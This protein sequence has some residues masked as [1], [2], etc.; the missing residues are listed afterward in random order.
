MKAKSWT[1]L[2]REKQLE[3]RIFNVERHRCRSQTREVQADFVV[4]DSRD[5]V[6]IIAITKGENIVVIKQYRAGT[7]E[8]TLEIPG[9]VCEPGEDPST[10]GLRELA[11]E[12]GYTAESHRV[13]GYVRPNPAFMNN[14]CYT[15]L[16]T[17]CEKAQ[18]TQ[19][20]D[21]EEIETFE[22]PLKE[23]P[24]LIQRGEIDH[25]L[26]WSAYVHLIREGIF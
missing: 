23:F 18:D 19:F 16:A 20:D 6:N 10:S 3:T 24:G 5:W 22:V 9:G 11:E 13:L 7:D 25:S 21:D 15:V 2:K 12:T 14:K 8:I 17:G 1:L 26:V 4:L